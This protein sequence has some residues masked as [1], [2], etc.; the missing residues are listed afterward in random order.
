MIIGWPNPSTAHI[1]LLMTDGTREG[2]GLGRTLHE[3]VVEKL[4]SLRT[5]DTIRLS[6]LDTNATVAEPFWKKMGYAATGEAVPYA[7]GK[8][9]STARIWVRPLVSA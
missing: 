4:V 8:V 2:R 5:V 9:A 6:I 3:T 7:S 1:G